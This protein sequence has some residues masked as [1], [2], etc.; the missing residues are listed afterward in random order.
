MLRI[1]TLV[2]LAIAVAACGQRPLPQYELTGTTMGTSFSV[3]IVTT[4]AGP[5]LERL[6]ADIHTR[7]D[8][9]DQ[10]MSTYIVDSTLSRFNASRDTEWHAVSG[11]V[12]A[13]VAAS[14]DISELSDG[15]FDVTVGPLV[16]LWGFGPEG[17]VGV[18]PDADEIAAAR[19][20]VGYSR[21]QADCTKPALRKS[22]EDLSVDLSAIAK[23]HAV[24]AVSALLDDAGLSDYLVEIGGEL[25]GQGFN[26]R[27]EKWAIAIETPDKGARKVQKIVGLTDFAMATSGDYRN[28]FEYEGQSFSHTIDPRTG[29]PVEH[30]AASVTVIAQSAEFAD[31]MA[32]AL[33]VLGAD[34]GL[35]L[36]EREHIAAFFL[37]RQDEGFEERMTTLFADRI[38]G[39]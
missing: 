1:G 34:A 36:A 30:E 39:G 14:L 24:D 22:A 15:A 27:R 37:L 4:G 13:V 8:S 38:S 9:L 19:Q 26:A 33:L 7:L 21:L 2:A 17:L 12:C 32:T 25:R 23:G 29:Y 16:D 11:D 35:E 3:K 28:Y 10:E 20:G 31:G 6:R 18:P 5:D